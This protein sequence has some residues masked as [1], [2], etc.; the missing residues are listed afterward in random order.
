MDFPRSGSIFSTTTGFA[1]LDRLLAR[2]NAQKKGLLAVLKRPEIPLHTNGS[3][4]DIRCQVTRRKISG[5]TRSDP[6][7]DSRDAFL[8]PMKTCAKHAVRFWGQDRSYLNSNRR[9]RLTPE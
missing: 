3:E 4:N 9:S 6:G 1:T 2:L 5:G 7:R 8:G